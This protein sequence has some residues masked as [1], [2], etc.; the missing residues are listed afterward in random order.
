M[1]QGIQVSAEFVAEGLTESTDVEN[2]I[3]HVKVYAQKLFPSFLMELSAKGLF[4]KY[5]ENLV[6]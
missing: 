5:P 2:I 3:P 1:S 6:S 4:K